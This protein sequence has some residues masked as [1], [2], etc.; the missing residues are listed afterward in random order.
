MNRGRDW[1]VSFC[2]MLLDSDL[3]IKWSLPS[4]TRSE[5][6]DE[7]VAGL[8]FA[9]GCQALTYAPESGSP[10]TL[11]RVK[12]SIKLPKMLQS[13]R[14]CVRQGIILKANMIFGFPGQTVREVWE[15]LV[16]VAKMAFVGVHD[17]AIF[18]FVPYP[19]SELFEALV[20]SG[21]IEKHDE[22][23]EQFLI[24]NIYNQIRG[25]R[26]WSEHFS[27]RT[28]QFLTVGGMLYFYLLMFSFR[29]WRIVQTI[30]RLVRGDHTTMFERAI[31]GV[32]ENWFL[33]RYRARKRITRFAD[34][35]RP[36][37]P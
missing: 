2:E 19:G 18:P 17:V 4:G 21:R 15:S 20:S 8:L 28:L 24:N 10:T 11:N 16:F 12:K 13:M 31:R 34:E 7:E 33:K 22:Q 26:S 37:G 9:A 29:P 30:G 35:R 27:S 23:Y 14:G 3:D 36:K 32:I 1:I 6:I 25:M 5:A